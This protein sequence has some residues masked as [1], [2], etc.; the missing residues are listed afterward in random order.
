MVKQDSCEKRM[1][2]VKTLHHLWFHDESVRAGEASL[3]LIY[4]KVWVKLCK[5][6][7]GS[8]L[9]QSVKTIVVV[10][11][12][13]INLAPYLPL[14]W[15][16]ARRQMDQTCSRKRGAMRHPSCSLLQIDWFWFFL[17]KLDELFL[18]V[19]SCTLEMCW[20]LHIV[21]QGCS[22]L[23]IPSPQSATY[24]VLLLS[25]SSPKPHTRK[26][27]VNFT[28]WEWPS[29]A[30]LNVSPIHPHKDNSLILASASSVTHQRN[31]MALFCVCSNL[32]WGAGTTP[33]EEP[34]LFYRLQEM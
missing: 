16:T 29:D 3:A 28:S 33:G 24:R 32:C 30:F 5:T 9:F 34:V 4:K 8:I 14:E 7:T 17:S 22:A 19:S 21:W 31:S 13:I 15:T 2:V 12:L 11:I 6:C 26:Q 1:L 27:V 20:I 18:Q 25:C 10:P 23:T